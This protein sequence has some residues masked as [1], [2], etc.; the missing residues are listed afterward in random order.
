MPLPEPA[1]PATKT[2]GS[3]PREGAAQLAVV[4]PTGRSRQ[5]TA[6][7]REFL[8]PLLEIQESPPSPLKRLVLLTI[9]GLVVALIVWASVGKMSIVATAPGKFI[10][11]GRVKTLQ[12][13]EASIVKSIHV[14]EGQHVDSGDLLL[15]LD[16]TLSAADMNASADKLAFNQLE[17]A[18]LVAEL[19]HKTPLYA[20]AGQ[21][22]GRLALEERIRQAREQ[23]HAAKLAGAQ[24]AVEEKAAA[25]AAAQ[26][27]LQKYHELTGIAEEREASARPL[28]ETG[29]IARI[30]YLQLK[31]D[32]AKNRNDFASQQETV[33]Q[34]RAAILEADR[35]LEQVRRDRVADIYKDLDD[36]VTS[37]PELNGGA[38]KSR[39]LYSLK[40]LR[41]PVSGYVQKVDVTTI[42]QVVSAAQSLV[43]IVPDGTPLIVEA[44]A[45][46]QDI[47]YLKV[48]QPVEIK[49]D[50]FPF[51]KYGS[52]KGTLEWIS[53][54]AEDRDGASTDSDTR[55]GTAEA[56]SDK[57]KDSATANNAGY[58]Y[59]IRVRTEQSQFRV[60][61]ETRPLQAGMTVQADITTDKRRVIDFFLS[62]VIKYLDEGLKV[63]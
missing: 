8:P 40:W 52:L 13:L 4:K 37:E 21:A 9:V 56:K 5:L 51:Q 50:T 46:N 63:R 22:P 28:V 39:E 1:A 30:D 35:A 20:S 62:P 55:S 19:T 49:V 27:T 33:Q 38:Q 26:A 34:A 60:N 11:E 42:G 45:T 25:L 17:Q 57:N 36:R 54:D 12:P 23:A 61:G 53:P 41:A 15:E 32:L 58:V 7:E 31:E 59:K 29:A 16:P 3:A 48:G 24:A 44:T 6:M 43:T 47:G 14:R 10:P 2:P 18:R